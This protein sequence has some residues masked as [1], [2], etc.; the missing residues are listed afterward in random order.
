MITLA[1]NSLL[2]LIVFP[3]TRS[4]DPKATYSTFS[5]RDAVLSDL[6]ARGWPRWRQSPA[7]YM[8]E[9]LIKNLRHAIAHGNVSFSDESR[10]LGAV[11]LKFENYY[12]GR[13]QWSGRIY[14]DDLF[15]FSR[16]LAQYL[17]NRV[18]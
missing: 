10:Q 2:G 15:E 17:I 8:L 11:E 9:N 6:Y 13:L 7:C 5:L 3:F 18:G 12:R 14:G 1:A 16:K 4:S